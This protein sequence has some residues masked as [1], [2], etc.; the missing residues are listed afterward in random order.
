MFLGETIARIRRKLPACY[1]R[2][3]ARSAVYRA[4]YLFAVNGNANFMRSSREWNE[5]TNHGN[6][7]G[8]EKEKE[9]EGEDPFRFGLSASKYLLPRVECNGSRL[10]ARNNVYTVGYGVGL[11]RPNI[12]Q[13][14]RRH[15]EPNLFANISSFSLSCIACDLLA[16]KLLD[17]ESWVIACLLIP[18]RLFSIA[19]IDDVEYNHEASPQFTRFVRC[20]IIFLK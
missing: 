5:R 4:K 18:F 17:P 13:Q 10:I 6:S 8:E 16:I 12:T 20:K 1:R 2:E 3:N 15:C 7:R 19:C 11:S 14:S 9:K